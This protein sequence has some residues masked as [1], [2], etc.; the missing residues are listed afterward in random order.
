MPNGVYAGQRALSQ[1]PDRFTVF[2]R[3]RH[4]HHG[5]AREITGF[6]SDREFV[7]D[8]QAKKGKKYGMPTTKNELIEQIFEIWDNIDAELKTK[9][10]E[11]VPKRL[12]KIIIRSLT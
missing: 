8:N 4:N 6:K 12:I 3:S 5:L 7:V 1:G 9:L 2:R 11:S 10:A